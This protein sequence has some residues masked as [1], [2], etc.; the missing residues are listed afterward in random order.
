MPSL[1]IGADRV[2]WGG[3]IVTLDPALPLA[4]AL[5]VRDGR[6]V[7]VG[8]RDEVKPWVAPRAELVDLGGAA[9]LPGFVESHNHLIMHGVSLGRL[10]ASPA[11]C[12]SIAD[13][14]ARVREEAARTPAGA[15][16]RGR[17]YDDTLVREKRALGRADLDA[18]AAP[19]YIGHIS[20]HL[21]Y[22]NSAA[23]ALA[24]IDGRTADPEGGHIVRD[25]AG[26][27]TGE[28]H[29]TATGLVGRLLPSE[30]Y[31]ETL[32][33]AW[34]GAAAFAKV[35]ITSAQDVSL[36]IR[37]HHFR[38][39]EAVAREP[40]YPLRVVGFPVIGWR[41]HLPVHTGFG[42]D[43]FRL[44]ALKI[45]SDGSIQG[46]TASL[47]RPYHDRPDTR[48][49]QV[50]APERLRELVGQAHAAGFQIAIHTNGDQAIEYA[51][52]AFEAAL[53]EHPRPDHRHRLE[54]CQTATEADLAR[55]ARLGVCASFFINH[56]WYWGD[57]HR[58]LFLGP[59]R[60][61]RI[62]PLASA[63]RHGIP[64]GLHCDAPV[65]PP[66]PLRSIWTAVT[67]RTRDGQVLGPEERIPVEAALRAYT[68]DAAYL[69]FEEHLKG[70]LEVGKLADFCLLSAS[71]LA[72]EPDAI[73][74]IRVL[75]TVLGGRDV[76][77]G[78]AA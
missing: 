15:W 35:G 78:G 62:D 8:T 63:L 26:E 37:S 16:V 56:V 47:R 2:F 74:E 17:G 71:P 22:V 38:V 11:V 55:M 28:L 25:A 57:R 45:I 1:P 67:R 60:A 53:A 54:H 41:E 33:A 3:P 10:D 40:G 76:A 24:G 31:E 72:V 4:E 43:R 20:G 34:R 6:I 21:A 75:G 14:V 23:L 51:L 52:D 39:Y 64:F 32:A 59:E 49:I 42:D 13:V 66:D 9:L 69:A 65:T 36:G 30:T 18:V 61:A 29:E 50:V 19:V 7:A 5:A 44:G 27:P 73:A 70:T 12:P 46:Y 58:D 77:V 68:V 48:G